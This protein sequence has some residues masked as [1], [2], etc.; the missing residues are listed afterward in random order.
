MMQKVYGLLC[1][2]LLA[3]NSF[4]QEEANKKFPGVDNIIQPSPNAASLGKFGGFDVTKYT[5]SINKAIEIF[6]LKSGDI[7]YPVSLAYSSNG[8]KVDDWGGQTGIGWTIGTHATITREVRGIAD[9]LASY[10]VRDLNMDLWYEEN[11]ATLL[12]FKNLSTQHATKYDGEYDLFHFN[13]FGNSG[14]F[15]IDN[16][17]AVLLNHSQKVKINILQTSPLGFEIITPEGSMYKFGNPNSTE[18]SKG[19]HENPCD[20]G[21]SHGETFVTTA[22][23]LDE[24]ISPKGD[25]MNFTYEKSPV[26]LR[27]LRSFEERTTFR[28]RR[29]EPGDEISCDEFRDELTLGTQITSCA[30]FRF[31]YPAILKSV[32]CTD[33]TVE[34][35]YTGRHR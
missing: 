17:L 2:L 23:Y 1:F 28:F 7:S 9:E 32:T 8:V 11:D 35:E 15:I 3:A 30:K 20:M 4:G 13:I 29:F 33:F 12:R 18:E 16:G 34:Y 5:G 14:S 10:S 21:I 31:L 22:W 27:M 25:V 19:D 6:N 26:P 24:I